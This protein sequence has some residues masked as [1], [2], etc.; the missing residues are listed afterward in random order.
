MAENS[1]FLGRLHVS[2]TEQY[3]FHW[4]SRVLLFNKQRDFYTR[5]INDFI[6]PA[7][8]RDDFKSFYYKKLDFTNCRE[9]QP[10]VWNRKSI[11]LKNFIYFNFPCTRGKNRFIIMSDCIPLNEVPKKLSY[12]KRQ[13]KCR[14]VQTF[15]R[16]NYLN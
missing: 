12:S 16:C 6:V 14:N 9:M 7:N 1:N 3:V 11:T 2:V 8:S 10:Y 5:Y 13:Y 4:K 15:I